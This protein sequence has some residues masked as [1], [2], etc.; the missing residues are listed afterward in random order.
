MVTVDGSSWKISRIEYG[1]ESVLQNSEIF[2]IIQRVQNCSIASVVLALD[3]SNYCCEEQDPTVKLI[4]RLQSSLYNWTICILK[5][6]TIGLGSVVI[7]M[8]T[9]HLATLF[10]LYYQWKLSMFL[11][12]QTY[13]LSCIYANNLWKLY[14]YMYIYKNLMFMNCWKPQIF[15][16]CEICSFTSM[17]P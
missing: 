3:S 2:R 9:M 8:L 12:L 11:V 16:T 14:T 1:M 10:I 5:C 13:F 4:W 17:I 15:Y 7:C 6:K